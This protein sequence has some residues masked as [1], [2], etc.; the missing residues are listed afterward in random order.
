MGP[1]VLR[2][3]EG[4]RE[5]ERTGMDEKFKAV[6]AILALLVVGEI[7]SLNRI[8]VL[9]KDFQAQEAQT[10]KQ[11]TDW[12]NQD[13]SS[14]LSAFEESNDAQLGALKI[15]MDEASRHLGVQRGELHR[16]RVLVTA[17][18]NEHNQQLS[19]LK[20]EIALKADQEQLGALTD[21]VS[22]TKTDLGKTK[23]NVDS[24]AD[25]L[26]MTRTKFGTLIARNHDEIAALRKLGERDYFEFSA[27]RHKSV[28]VGGVGVDLKKTNVKH[29]RFNVDLMVDDVWLEKKNRTINEPIFFS[30]RGSRTFCELVVNRVDKGSI[31]GYIS[32]PKGATQMASRLEGTR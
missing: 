29:H 2:E 20:H 22:Q 7:F 24:L 10:R 18:Q 16:A 17:L 8:H 32:T 27:E 15:E 28:R 5:G 11:L 21:D 4:S 30:V 1:D 13:I 31:T 6:L 23:K 3:Q 9:R 26:G 14:K 25:T 19:E 12:V